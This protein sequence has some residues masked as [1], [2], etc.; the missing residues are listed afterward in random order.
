MTHPPR[1]WAL[2]DNKPG[3]ASQVQGVA[4]ALEWPYV[5]K[6]I[7]YT[8]VA[9]LPN[10]FKGNGLRGIDEATR[11]LLTPPWPDIVIA[12]GRKTAPVAL[13]IKQQAQ[14]E[15]QVP[16]LAV[17][18][19]WPG[20]PADDFDIIAVPEH[21]IYLPK[22]PNLLRTLGAPHRITPHVLEKEAAMWRKTLGHLKSPFL[23][24]LVG[25]D[26]RK[27]ALDKTQAEM[28]AAAVNQAVR[29]LGGSALVSTSRRT[30][31]ES[32]DAL[33]FALDCPLYFHDPIKERTNPY[34]A[35]LGLCDAVI[36]TGDSVSMCSE[37]CATGKPVFIFSGTM[38]LPEK[39]V[40]FQKALF[41]H[42]YAQSLRDMQ[43]GHWIEHIQKDPVPQP[44]LYVADD[45]AAAIREAWKN[46]EGQ[47][48]VPS[49]TALKLSFFK[50][51]RNPE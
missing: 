3:H 21:D 11:K 42:G 45:I 50:R 31:P 24:V 46:K 28:L 5:S 26:T 15:K 40:Y 9:S 2:L 48:Y 30:K 17:Q 43:A 10:M 14:A 47:G 38:P 1:I 32:V 34:L 29:E 36:V 37:A 25:G 12:A 39:H 13:W 35:F 16:C 49:K 22:L 27:G 23:A 44:T 7:G 6:T 51:M 4:D 19:M 33:K 20:I 41:A 18:L 8:K